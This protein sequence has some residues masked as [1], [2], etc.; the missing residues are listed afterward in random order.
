MLRNIYNLFELNINNARLYRE[1]DLRK[2]IVDFINIYQNETNATRIAMHN[3]RV[4]ADQ[5]G[6]QDVSRILAR[7]KVSELQSQHMQYHYILQ[8]LDGLNKHYLGDP[9]NTGK[10]DYRKFMIGKNNPEYINVI[11]DVYKEYCRFKARYTIAMT[12]AVGG[13]I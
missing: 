9:D 5:E 2:C 4:M 7:M 6:L 13:L 8:F 10:P 3:M 1:S 12:I 11:R